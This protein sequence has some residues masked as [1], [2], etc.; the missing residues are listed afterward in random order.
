MKISNFIIKDISHIDGKGLFV[1][2]VETSIHNE[3]NDTANVAIARVRVSLSSNATIEE[4]ERGLFQAARDH[5][6]QVG[7][8]YSTET[9]ES[10]RQRLKEYSDSLQ[11]F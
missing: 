2:Q 9:P 7:Q 8:L 11:T 10:M 6:S 4:I 3:T 1:G 5:L